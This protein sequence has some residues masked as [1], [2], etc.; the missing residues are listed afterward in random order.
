MKW[1]GC[2]KLGVWALG[3][4]RICPTGK[5]FISLLQF[6]GSN[7]CC[8]E[9]INDAFIFFYLYGLPLDYYLLYKIEVVAAGFVVSSQPIQSFKIK[10][11]Y[12]T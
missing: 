4:Y 8:S 9:I 6:I 11:I 3:R 7:L 12:I 5:I 1:P 2:A 10:P